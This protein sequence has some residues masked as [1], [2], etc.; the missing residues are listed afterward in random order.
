MLAPPTQLY[1]RNPGF[2]QALLDLRGPEACEYLHGQGTRWRGAFEPG[3]HRPRSH[4]PDVVP[5]RVAEGE[6]ASPVETVSVLA[7]R[8]ARSRTPRPDSRIR[9]E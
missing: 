2:P 6:A 9:P 8:G 3:G 1:P 5:G 4:D 7:F